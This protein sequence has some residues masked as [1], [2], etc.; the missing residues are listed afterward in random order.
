MS[1]S[2]SSARA[3]L[4]AAMGPVLFLPV[5]LPAFGVLGGDASSV[6]QDGARMKSAVRVISGMPYSVHEMCDS[7]GTTVREFVSPAGL[8]FAVSW[9]GPYTPDLRQLLGEY[10]DQ[11]M[12]AAENSERIHRRMMHLEAGDLVFESSGH[13]RSIVGRAYLRSKLPEGASANV[14]R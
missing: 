11:Y 5:C 9:Q 1:T 7:N 8:V 6:Q 2:F 12:S 13:M 4:A 10:Y 3:A 14:I